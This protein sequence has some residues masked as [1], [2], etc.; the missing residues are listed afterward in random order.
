M[1]KEIKRAEKYRIPVNTLFIKQ[2]F[3]IKENNYVLRQKVIKEFLSLILP[4]LS[5]TD[6]IFHLFP[7]TFALVMTQDTKR[8][9]RE[10]AEKLLERL[11]AKKIWADGDAFDYY[12]N[13]GI[14]PNES[15]LTKVENLLQMGEETIK[16][17]RLKGPNN[18]AFYKEKMNETKSSAQTLN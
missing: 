14:I 12:V 8:D 1:P 5:E 9:I 18:L 3:Q 10:F 7:D 2:Y 15:M 13:I 11:S 16:Q 4:V 17:A 6:Y